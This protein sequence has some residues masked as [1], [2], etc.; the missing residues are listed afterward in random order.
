[1]KYK[2]VGKLMSSVGVIGGIVLVGLSAKPDDSYAM[3]FAE[4]A[5]RIILILAGIIITGVSYEALGEFCE[6]RDEE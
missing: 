1:M 3:G 5:L 2:T 4:F 6:M